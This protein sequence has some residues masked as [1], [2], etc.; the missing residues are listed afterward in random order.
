MVCRWSVFTGSCM[1]RANSGWMRNMS[2][3]VADFGVKQVGPAGAMILAFRG[4][5][6]ASMPKSLASMFQSPPTMNGARVASACPIV[7]SNS[8]VLAAPALSPVWP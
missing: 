6:W 7:Y 5:L 4:N 3:V 2:R 8:L 1:A